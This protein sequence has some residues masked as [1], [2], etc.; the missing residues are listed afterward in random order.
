VI[1]DEAH[2]LHERVDRR[3]EVQFL[4]NGRRL[5]AGYEDG[6]AR[7]WET[8][9]GTELR[10][11][12][13]AAGRSGTALLNRSSGKVLWTAKGDTGAVLFTRTEDFALTSGN[14]G[15]H[16]RRVKD[17]GMTQTVP[18]P[19]AN[20]VS[21]SGDGTMLLAS[22]PRRGGEEQHGKRCKPTPVEPPTLLPALP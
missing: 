3:G 16:I 9:S 21:L 10:V 6:T 2:G 22:S 14:D 17:G 13:V 19:Y 12:D 20:A 5:C 1:V 7:L 15:V 11:F 8:A 18:M 4:D